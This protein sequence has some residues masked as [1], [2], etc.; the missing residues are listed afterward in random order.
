M[1]DVLAGTVPPENASVGM[2]ELRPE[3]NVKHDFRGIHVV[4][5]VSL[6]A[7]LVTTPIFVKPVISVM[8]LG[9]AWEVTS[10]LQALIARL[11]HAILGLVFVPPHFNPMV[12]AVGQQLLYLEWDNQ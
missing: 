7:T 12:L 4:L 3:S 8:E 11:M 2:G 1:Q 6:L 10:V 5:I 9:L